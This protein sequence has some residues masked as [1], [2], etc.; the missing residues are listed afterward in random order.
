MRVSRGVRRSV[1]V[2]AGR[3]RWRFCLMRTRA[4]GWREDVAPGQVVLALGFGLLTGIRR[5]AR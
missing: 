5:N 1:I 2:E 4:V 3:W